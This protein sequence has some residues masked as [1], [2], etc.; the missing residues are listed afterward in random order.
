[1]G[2]ERDAYV[3]KLKIQF[4]EWNAE[5]DKLQAQADQAQADIR[6]TYLKHLIQLKSKRQVLKEKMAELHQAGEGAWED[7]KKSVDMAQKILS[8]SIQSAKSRFS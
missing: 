4:D 7:V 2:E 6:T 3:E 8:E 1:M 5:I